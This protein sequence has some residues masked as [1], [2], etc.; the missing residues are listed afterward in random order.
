MRFI[1]PA[2]QRGQLRLEALSGV[3]ARQLLPPRLRAQ[4]SLWLLENGQ[5]HGRSTAVLR[6]MWLLGWPWKL[7]APL[8]LV[9]QP[10]R[11]WVYGAIAKRRQ[12]S[13]LRWGRKA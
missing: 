2:S 1:R 9:P 11:D 3:E 4:D 10:M 6:L 5:I 12:G 13:S 7:A 8:L